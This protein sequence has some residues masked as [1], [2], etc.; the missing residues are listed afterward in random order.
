MSAVIPKVT[1][2]SPRII[3]VLG[4][5]PSPMTLQGTNTY[6]IGTG[7]RR[8]LLDVGEPGNNEYIS[9][10]AQ[11]LKQNNASLEKIVISHWHH[12]H[13][14]GL[15]D[16]L[17]VSQE[18]TPS[19]HK[20][21]RNDAEE[22]P[23]IVDLLSLTHQQ[24]MKVEGATVRV[25]HTP[26]HTT[27]HV[28]LELPEERAVFSGDCILGEGTAVFED[29]HSYMGSLKAILDL[30]PEVIYPGHGPVIENPIERIKHY[31]DHRN[32]RESQIVEVLTESPKKFLKAMELVKTIYK[33]TP[34][35]LHPA[36][37]V[38]VNHHLEKLLKDGLVYRE[39]N[40]WCLRARK[41]QL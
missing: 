14:G 3:R 19:V 37:E 11:V 24:E 29:L 23:A 4:C 1:H 9:Q 40:T 10:L 36:A 32:Q 2:I 8:L 22:E 6:L 21:P 30:E 17:K 18:D 39:N 16:V 13:I 41:D 31:I 20:F 28:I 35:I 12:D 38:N 25:H 27:D 26:G 7:R 15:G 33:E 34:E 5:N